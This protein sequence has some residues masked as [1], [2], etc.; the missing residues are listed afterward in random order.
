MLHLIDT[1]DGMCSIIYKY[2]LSI[3]GWP[4]E[5]E[6]PLPSRGKTGWKLKTWILLFIGKE[7]SIGKNYIV[8]LL[9]LLTL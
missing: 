3:E 5:E 9:E 8:F 6:K 2:I 7:L 1:Y 4:W